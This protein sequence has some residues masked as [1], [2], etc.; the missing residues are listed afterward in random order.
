MDHPLTITELKSRHNS[1]QKAYLKTN[2]GK[3]KH[4]ISMNRYL[5]LKR[6]M[7]KNNCDKIQ[8]RA[9]LNMP[10]LKCGTKRK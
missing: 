3:A 6:Y 5:T 2:N 4:K 1:Q 10:K 7:K 9:D 8:A